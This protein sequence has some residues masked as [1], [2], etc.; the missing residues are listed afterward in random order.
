M[1][2]FTSKSTLLILLVLFTHNGAFSIENSEF[3]NDYRLPKSIIPRKYF[4]N[5]EKIDFMADTFKGSVEIHA[6]V[7]EKTNKI[8]LHKG[9][10]L[11]ITDVK[12]NSSIKPKEVKINDKAEI[13]T[14]LLDSELK[15]SIPLVFTLNFKGK[16]RDDMI[17]FY[18]SSYNESNKERYLA[19]TQFESTH[20]RHAFPCFDEPAF[21]A[22]FS[23]TIKPPG[24]NY[25]C[26]SNMPQIYTRYSSSKPKKICK[27]EQSVE[28]STYLVAF[29]VADF[30]AVKDEKF[31]VW[32]RRDA[33]DQSKYALKIGQASQDYFSKHLNI[34]YSLSKMDMV[35][36]PDFSAGAMENWGLITY[37]ETAVLY[38]GNHSSNAAMQRVASVIVHEMAHQWFGNLVTPEW[39]NYLWLSEGFARYYEYMGTH[40]DAENWN[41][42]GQFVVDHLQTSFSTDGT[43]GTHPVSAK[44][45]TPSEIKGIFDKISYAKAASLIRMLEK[46]TGPT[47][48]YG[49]L[50]EYLKNRQY[51]FGTP[52]ALFI[53]FQKQIGGGKSLTKFDIIEVMNSW[54]KQP[55][56]PVVHVS[57]KNGSMTLTQ[58]RF[59]TRPP[60]YNNSKSIWNIPIT[61]TTRTV[62]DFSD[63][64]DVFWLKDKT[65]TLE[66]RNAN[67]NDWIILNLQQAGYYRVN[68]DEAMW[69]LIISDLH[70]ESRE[71]IHPINR[72]NLIDDLFNLAR[73]GEI[74]YDIVLSATDYLVNETDYVPWKAAL[75]NLNYLT[76]RFV[77]RG[78]VEQAYKDYVINLLE[79]SFKR[80]G[81]FDK[82]Y[83][84]HTD[85]LLRKVV[86]ETL[87]VFGYE[88]CINEAK[89]LFEEERKQVIPIVPPNQ[90][91]F[92]Y[93][94]IA[95]HG[96]ERNWNYLY[97][98]FTDSIYATEKST[99][100]TALACSS[101][102]DLLN[103]LGDYS[104]AKSTISTISKRLSTQELVDKVHFLN[105]F[106]NLSCCFI[107]MLGKIYY[108]S[109]FSV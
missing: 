105:F 14:I 6:D 106:N 101:K 68:Y 55:G 69:R 49:A 34:S 58:K 37:R 60:N 76:K 8:S 20:A 39:W 103:N 54:T 43:N 107:V 80:L 35:A 71:R 47:A 94:A 100:I 52:T 85:I 15:K 75:T 40:A 96:D 23:V 50:Q 45:Y 26:L 9:K 62:A 13:Y 31:A 98:K 92:V 48:F 10:Y 72:A 11:N 25:I 78:F 90:Q 93:S 88:K 24:D 109:L 66:V 99:L 91:L 7:K 41:L 53:P 84:K 2:V 12:I 64:R 74:G 70:S 104:V 51:S 81:F 3:E 27:F 57:F 4:I 32:S 29:I 87:C 61:Y 21:K 46:L 17:G 16:L 22:N 59:Y 83:D 42:E 28:M 5:Y 30:E 38:D 79:P 73:A 18:K 19:A 89:K 95:R 33:V 77:G 36:V 1:N 97:K 63:F 67:I 44:V 86:L 102:P 108:E 65:A 82:K 56:F